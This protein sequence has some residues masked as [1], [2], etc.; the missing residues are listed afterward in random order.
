MWRKRLFPTISV[1]PSSCGTAEIT[2]LSG[3]TIRYGC[4]AVL[5]AVPSDGYVF[6]KFAFDGNENTE[7]DAEVGPIL[8]DICISVFFAE[9]E[10][11]S[12]RK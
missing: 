3:D 5:H 11:T 1:I 9:N 12:Y 10:L 4:N 7:N 8:S 2:P 6:Q